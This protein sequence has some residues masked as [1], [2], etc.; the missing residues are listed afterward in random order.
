MGWAPDCNK[1]LFKFR[2]LNPWANRTITEDP[3]RPAT[4]PKYYYNAV[5]LLFDGFHVSY[6]LSCVYTT[7]FPL[8]FF[9]FLFLHFILA[10]YL[11]FQVAQLCSTTDRFGS[12][13]VRR[14]SGVLA[15]LRDYACTY[16]AM[17]RFLPNLATSLFVWIQEIIQSRN[18]AQHSKVQRRRRWRRILSSEEEKSCL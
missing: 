3:P 17:L 5:Q 9:F 18:R 13:A 8:F 16:D 10:S 12:A 2:A 15:T 7:F 1:L 4:K 11:R 6:R 14:R